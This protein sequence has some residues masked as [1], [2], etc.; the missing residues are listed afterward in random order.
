L[1]IGF[2]FFIIVESKRIRQA[3]RKEKY[4]MKKRVIEMHKE[5]QRIEREEREKEHRPRLTRMKT[6]LWFP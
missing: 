5:K 1:P 4:L 6:F 3:E 2:F